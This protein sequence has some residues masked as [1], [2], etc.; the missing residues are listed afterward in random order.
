MDEQR[1]HEILGQQVEVP[2]MIN[3]KLNDTY[4][5]L[6]G[7]RRLAK[8]KGWKPVRTVLIAAALI[9]A[10]CVTVTAAYQIFRQETIMDPAKTVEGILSGGQHAWTETTVHN[11]YGLIE[12]YW[13]N[14]ETVPVDEE[15][16][17]ALLG[18][19]LP[20]CGYRWQI[21]DYTLT[22][23]GYV[24][25]EHTGTA[26]FYY[27]VEHPGGFPEGSVTPNTGTLSY[28][29]HINVLF[30]TKSDVEWKWI[31]GKITFVDM[32]RS[33]PEKLYLM[34]GAAS[35]HH[36]WK[37][38][39][40]LS[41]K[42]TITG[43]TDRDDDI[44]S[45]EL[46]LP[47]VKSLPVVEIMHPETGELAAAISPIAVRADAR[48]IIEYLGP[49]GERVLNSVRYIALEYADGTNYVIQDIGLDSADYG[50]YDDEIYVVKV[51]NR[52]VD[53]SQVTA[54]IVDGNRYEV[55]R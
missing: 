17:K 36:D 9:A 21:E 34:E 39:D 23:E 2:H 27:S 38:E 49:E 14:R 1:L 10:M 55:G 52:L 29:S 54:V 18:D 8:R 45:A 7:K 43:E 53:P 3:K 41:V 44:L 24:L 16:A 42:F 15:Q 28:K 30:S 51:F 13:P 47:G 25:D 50:M 22:V 6:E 31:S 5:Q 40:G 48:H 32:E 33:T 20:E 46:D 37:A 4:A 11:E 19:Y 26:R 35:A 12:G